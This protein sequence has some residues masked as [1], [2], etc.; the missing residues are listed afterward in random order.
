[1]LLHQSFSQQ[2]QSLDSNLATQLKLGQIRNLVYEDIM[3]N[4]FVVQ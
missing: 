1:M 3:A 2:Q 4:L